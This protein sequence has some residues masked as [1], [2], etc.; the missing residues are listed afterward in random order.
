MSFCD[1]VSAGR[2]SPNTSFSQ[3][4]FNN[5]P[6]DSHPSRWSANSGSTLTS[7]TPSPTGA[8]GCVNAFFLCYFVFDY[9]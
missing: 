5:A 6:G 8:Y 7:G 1:V 4:G 3:P 9:D 2:G